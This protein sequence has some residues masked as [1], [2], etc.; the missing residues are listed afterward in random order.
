MLLV[1]LVV[2]KTPIKRVLMHYYLS[3]SLFVVSPLLTRFFSLYCP[4]YIMDKIPEL[5]WLVVIK[6]GFI[7]LYIISEERTDKLYK[8]VIMQIL[9]LLAALQQPQLPPKLMKVHPCALGAKLLLFKIQIL[10]F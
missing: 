4:G 10:I 9:L 5:R 8:T 2:T 1:D 6:L 7:I 3:A